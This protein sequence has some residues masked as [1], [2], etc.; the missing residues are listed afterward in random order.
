MEQRNEQLRGRLHRGQRAEIITAVKEQ[1]PPEDAQA[2]HFADILL[3]NI[4][5]GTYADD[6]G[7]LNAQR[8]RMMAE[9]T[10]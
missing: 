1:L 8:D 3:Q 6:S 7:E 5:L 4:E 2:I 10:L 9:N